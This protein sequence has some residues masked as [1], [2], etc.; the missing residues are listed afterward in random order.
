MRM[1]VATD[2]HLGFMERDPIRG[3]D[4]FAAFEE[5]L[6][7]GAWCGMAWCGGQ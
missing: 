5:I 4:S 7:T 3:A 1:L 6:A 2:S